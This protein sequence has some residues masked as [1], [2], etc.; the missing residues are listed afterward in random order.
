[1]Y[2][3]LANTLFLGK[4]VIYL[5]VCHSTNDLAM[6]MLKSGKVTEGS[7]VIAGEQTHGK[8]QRGNVWKSAPDENLTFSL[9][10][11]P[12]F[13]NAMDQFDLNIMV[14]L[15]V[16]EALAYFDLEL[17]VK[18]PNDI[19]TKNGYKVG[20]ILFENVI[21]KGKVSGSVVGI[22]LNVNQRTIG[23]DHATSLINISKRQFDLK[24]VFDLIVHRI[25]QN[26]IMLKSGKHKQLKES[27]LKQMYLFNVW[28][29]YSDENEF[30]GK[31]RGIADDGKLIIEKESGMINF[32]AFKEV[33]FIKE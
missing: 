17:L 29:K 33:R 27:Y 24:T 13:L 10:L 15:A 18:W 16:V 12:S 21:S 7:I 23:L 19:Y 26:Y 3:I 25:E 1:M 28:S 14:S 32:Y 30:F 6:D 11:K 22:G 2:K 8:G 5:P 4:E 20:G 9:V 31:I